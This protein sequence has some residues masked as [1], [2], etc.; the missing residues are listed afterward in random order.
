MDLTQ[1]ILPPLGVLILSVLVWRFILWD[2]E[3]EERED[4]KK[5]PAE[6]LEEWKDRQW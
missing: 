2:V 3:R 6:R 4:A 1:I 5:T